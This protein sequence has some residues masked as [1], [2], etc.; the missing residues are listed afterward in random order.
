[1]IRGTFASFALGAAIFSQVGLAHA[2]PSIL[3]G[4]LDRIIVAQATPPEAQPAPA[5]P[6]PS[7]GQPHAAP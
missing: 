1:M 4:I 7:Q 6:A 5:Q 3:D 2:D